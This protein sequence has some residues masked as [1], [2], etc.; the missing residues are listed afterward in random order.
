MSLIWTPPALTTGPDVTAI[1]P[2]EMHLL[3]QLHAV[4]QKYQLVLACAHCRRPFQGQNDG[5]SRTQ[6]I[7]CDCRELRAV[8]PQTD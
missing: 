2:A 3:E 8:M 5:Q 1:L 4:A 7:S 6:A